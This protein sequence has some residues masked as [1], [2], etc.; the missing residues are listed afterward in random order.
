MTTGCVSAA[1][2]SPASVP[3][4]GNPDF[5]EIRICYIPDVK[6]VEQ[7]FETL[8]GFSFHNHGCF[9]RGLREHHNEDLIHLMNL[10]I[11]R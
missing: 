5:A 11:L 9:P 7:E 4:R 6:M 1:P 8:L 3:S 2:N 10:S